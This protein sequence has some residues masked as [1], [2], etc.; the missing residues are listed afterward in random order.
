MVV[1]RKSIDALQVAASKLAQVELQTEHFWADGMYCRSLFRPADTLI[2]GKV[3]RKEHLYIV[4]SGTVIIAGDG[5]REEI[6]GP[7]VIVS[8]PGTKRAVYAVTDATTMT[9][10]RTNETD[11]DLI[12]VELIE[13]DETAMFD[14][15]NHIKQTIKEL[16]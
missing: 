14:S 13:E 8:K 2:V 10:H 6:T 4:A 11:L 15:H 1:T 7:K 16:T 3:H 9:V 5:Y 12:E